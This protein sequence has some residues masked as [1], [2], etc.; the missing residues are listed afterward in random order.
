MPQAGVVGNVRE[1]GKDRGQQLDETSVVELN[2]VEAVPL[3][4]YMAGPGAQ[5]VAGP[6]T[7]KKGTEKEKQKSRP[8]TAWSRWALTKQAC[9]L[10]PTHYTD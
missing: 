5:R 9:R 2:L 7:N 3:S 10:A 1:D 8:L 6:G 4:K